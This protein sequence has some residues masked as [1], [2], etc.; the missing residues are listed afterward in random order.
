MQ[1]FNKLDIRIE[2]LS[3]CAKAKGSWVDTNK[4]N[5]MEWNGNGMEMEMNRYNKTDSATNTNLSL[6]CSDGC[7]NRNI[8]I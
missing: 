3:D 4:Y 7:C 5:G 1:L 2:R 6:R 8:Y